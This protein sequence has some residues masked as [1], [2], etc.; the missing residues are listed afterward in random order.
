MQR[1]TMKT[2]VFGGL[3]CAVLLNGLG[4]LSIDAGPLDNWI[5]RNSGASANLWGIAFG[6]NSFVAVGDQGTVLASQD[7][8]NWWNSRVSGVAQTLRGVTY[9]GNQFVACGDGG[10]L[11]TSTNGLVWTIRIQEPQTLFM[12]LPSGRANTFP[13]VLLVS[14]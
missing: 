12:E 9:G 14:F 6:N 3:S 4:I 10:T 13:S 7:G 8:V 11:L 5:T 2:K 1:L